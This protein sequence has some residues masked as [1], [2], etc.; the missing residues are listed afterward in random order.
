MIKTNSKK[1]EPKKAKKTEKVIHPVSET[2]QTAIKAVISAKKAKKVAESNIKKNEPVVI[3]HGIRFQEDMFF[4]KSEF[5]KSY[6]F[7]DADDNVTFVTAN[8]WGFE[9]G[10]VG[11]IHEIIED[12]DGSVED[13]M[14]QDEPIV[15]FKSEVFSDPV[16]QK[17]LVKLVGKKFDRYFE[18]IEGKWGVKEDFDKNVLKLGPGAV[19][20][21]KVY[22]K[23][24]KPSLR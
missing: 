23:K 13:L 9:Q 1:A 18:T 6:K 14:E 21:L 3:D 7:G 15:K 19:E 8:K 17:E 12:A 2:V 16:I 22:M 11:I 24:S 20:D 5:N 4:D 10:D